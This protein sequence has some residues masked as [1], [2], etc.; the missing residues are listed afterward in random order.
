M[1]EL[2][3]WPGDGRE[4]MHRSLIAGSAGQAGSGETPRYCLQCLDKN[5]YGTSLDVRKSRHPHCAEVLDGIVD[6]LPG[7]LD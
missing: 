5:G 7:V 3:L 4:E 6:G 2:V 1:E